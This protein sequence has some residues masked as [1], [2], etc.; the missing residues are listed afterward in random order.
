MD[1]WVNV[2]TQMIDECD[3][4]EKIENLHIHDNNEIYEQVVKVLERYWAQEL[5][6]GG[7]AAYPRWWYRKS[8]AGFGFCYQPAQHPN[9]PPGGF[10]FG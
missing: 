6:R 9:I 2:Y 3:G 7:R 5:G 1:N 10:K 4:V 8:A